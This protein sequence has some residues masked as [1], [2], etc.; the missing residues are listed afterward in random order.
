MKSFKCK[1]RN[2]MESK[3]GIFFFLEDTYMDNPSITI[4]L[5]KLF[6]LQMFKSQRILKGQLTE[7]KQKVSFQSSLKSQL[8]EGLRKRTMYQFSAAANYGSPYLLVRESDRK[9]A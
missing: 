4:K 6:F 1:E 7:V 8:V 9:P 2:I 3:V 5:P